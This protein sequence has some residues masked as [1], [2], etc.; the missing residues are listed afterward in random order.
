MFNGIY[1]NKKV[2]ITGNTGFKG[3]WLTYWLLQEGAIVH[4]VSNGIP[5]TPSLFEVLNLNSK[6]NYNEFDICNA[7]K[8]ADLIHHTKPDFIFHLAAQAL[9]KT[10][11]NEPL[12]TFNTNVLG[13]AA[14]LDA[15]RKCNHNVTAVIVTSDKC[16]E[17]VEWEQGY[18]ETDRLGGKDIYSASKGAA[19]L[20]YHAYYH[21]F[22]KQL[23]RVKTAT[24]R[25]G[26]V[27][28]GGDWAANRI[29]PD[30][31]RSWSQNL[32]VI[33]RNPNA[34]RPWQHVFE[35]LSGY[36]RL[37]QLLFENKNI[38]G[39]SYNFGPSDNQNHTVAEVIEK[40]SVYSNFKNLNDSFK[41]DEAATKFH[42][43]CLLKLNCEKAFVQ[44]NWEPTL[45]FSETT[46]FTG[47]WYQA[48]YSNSEI[49]TICKNQFDAYIN[50]A[51][52]NKKAWTI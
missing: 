24:A 34:T 50:L 39:E 11:L 46:K 36:L 14:V 38:N 41:L 27:I 31:F 37:G 13:T 48:F 52:A 20:V 7:Q 18:K 8:T 12:T 21:T 29:V 45:N 42:E 9:V 30:C 47:Q 28:G 35:P 49:N 2:L 51:K 17:N 6:I 32:P 16:Y 23:N 44:L 33:I 40:L 43:A 5:S 3:A 1:Q 26:N 19:E 25:A 15:I 10:S 4:A 22:L